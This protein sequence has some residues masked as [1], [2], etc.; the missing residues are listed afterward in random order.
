MKREGAK[1]VDKHNN[2]FWQFVY[3]EEK[4]FFLCGGWICTTNVCKI[5]LPNCAKRNACIILLLYYNKERR[6][7]GYM[8]RK[9]LLQK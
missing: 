5:F 4:L 6:H 2:N 7:P 8:R 3:F 9:V 1:D